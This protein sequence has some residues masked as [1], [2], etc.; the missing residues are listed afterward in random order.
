M[1]GYIG[2]RDFDKLTE[3]AELIDKKGLY[4]YDKPN[5]TFSEVRAQ[6]RRMVHRHGC[7]AIFI[8]Y[9]QL[10]RTGNKVLDQD[11]TRRV[12]TVST[13]L[14]NLSRELGIPVVA[15]AQIGRQADGRRPTLG[16]FQWASQIEQDADAAILLYW[17]VK[18][19][20]TGRVLQKN[21]VDDADNEELQIYALI[22][23]A[24]DGRKGAVPLVFKPDYVT[25]YEQVDDR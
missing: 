25:F 19:R 12:A 10:I 9:L 16:D 20:N 14:K 24:R 8:D 13:S 17:R 21:Q 7:R 1:S 22:D 15:L 11:L 23:K 4:V 2:R 5:C 3:A 18:D 6:A